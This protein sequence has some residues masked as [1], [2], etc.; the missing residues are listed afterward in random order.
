LLFYFRS[1]IIQAGQYGQAFNKQIINKSSYTEVGADIKYYCFM[2][3]RSQNLKSYC[4]IFEPLL[5]SF[6]ER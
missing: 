5:K 6:H 1:A 3:A 2:Q 4:V